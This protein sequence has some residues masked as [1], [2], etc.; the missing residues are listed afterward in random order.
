MSDV[1]SH[2]EYTD[3]ESISRSI[4]EMNKKFPSVVQLIEVSLIF[5]EGESNFLFQKQK[6]ALF[7]EFQKSVEVEIL[8]AEV[9]SQEGY[10]VEERRDNDYE[11]KLAEIGFKSK[12]SV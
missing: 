2:Y 10:I 9:C 1:L 11:S 7:E 6:S 12:D 8:K 3:I 4:E 5:E